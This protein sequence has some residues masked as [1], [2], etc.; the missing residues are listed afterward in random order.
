MTSAFVYLVAILHIGSHL[1]IGFF[2]Y[3]QLVPLLDFVTRPD[4]SASDPLHLEP[5]EIVY[6]AITAMAFA[7]V[8]VAFLLA[9][10][11]PVTA[12]ITLRG[13]A[14][15]SVFFHLAWTVHMV[16]RWDDAWRAMMHPDGGLTPEF[17]LYSH[18]AWTVLAGIVFV[19]EEP[20]S[21]TV[22]TKTKTH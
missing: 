10:L 8:G 7:T 3:T 5:L 9:T 1:L 11:C 22:S 15:L 20:S 21:S 12:G 2:D 14:A 18:A 19:L 13:A 17:F 16:W 4:G 6:A